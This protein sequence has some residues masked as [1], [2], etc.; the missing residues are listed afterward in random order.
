[1]SSN[2]RVSILVGI[3]GLLIILLSGSIGYIFANIESKNTSSTNTNS[4]ENSKVLKEIEEL[5]VLYDTKIADK[6]ISFTEMQIQKDSIQNLVSYSTFKSSISLNTL[7][8]SEV[9]DVE[10][11]VFLD[12]ILA[13]I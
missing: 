5:K 13:K 9:L 6:T 2:K 8:F 3:I 7:K 4:I 1:M 10:E 12:S 11:L